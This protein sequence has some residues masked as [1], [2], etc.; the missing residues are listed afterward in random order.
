[1]TEALILNKEVTLENLAKAL[2]EHDWTFQMSDD[3]CYWTSGNAYRAEIKELVNYFYDAGKGQEV[4]D[5]FY[6]EW[7][8]DGCDDPKTYG[9]KISWDDHLSKKADNPVWF[10]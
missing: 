10:P 4:E 2:K 3:H 8:G 7:P 9:I 5:L 6:A 1:M